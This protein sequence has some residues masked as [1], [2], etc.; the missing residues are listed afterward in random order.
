MPRPILPASRLALGLTVLLTIM[1]AAAPLD[2]QRRPRPRPSAAPSW[3]PIEIGG[4][5]G[6]DNFSRRGVLGGQI[7]VP[8]IR[9]GW[10]ALVPS[11]DVTFLNGLKEYQGSVDLVYSPAR[12]GSGGLFLGGGLALRNT[13]YD[14]TATPGSGVKETRAGFG[15]TAG[16]R[17]PPN[18][19]LPFG[20]QLG[21]RWIFVDDVLRPK[22]LS[23]SVNFPLWGGARGRRGGR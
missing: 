18:A 13:L 9:G 8:V 2:A 23:L 7:R 10:L 4:M 16:V 14:A 3:A 6:Y 1:A 15:V 12:R 22:V 21:I 5:V 17:S 19:G 11:G 20:T